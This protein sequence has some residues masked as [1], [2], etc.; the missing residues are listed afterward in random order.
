MRQIKPTSLNTNSRCRPHAACPAC[1]ESFRLADLSAAE[2]TTKGLF[3]V[4]F[5]DRLLSSF[6]TNHAP[7]CDT[8][9]PYIR[10][11]LHSKKR[12]NL[13][14]PCHRPPSW[15]LVFDS[16]QVFFAGPVARHGTAAKGEIFDWIRVRIIDEAT[17]REPP[18]TI[19]V[20]GD[21]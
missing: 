4:F 21:C 15:R 10:R 2:K 12:S 9:F 5:A 11:K 14:K 1:C 16:N 17:G 19:A 18:E 3:P 8:W 13:E 7:S 20:L 6:G